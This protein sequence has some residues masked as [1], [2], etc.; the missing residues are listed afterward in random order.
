MRGFN[1]IW[2]HDLR[3]TD[4]ILPTELWSLAGI[5]SSASSI[6]TRYMKSEMMCIYYKSWN[7]TAV[8]DLTGFISYAYNLKQQRETNT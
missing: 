4:V 6:Y 8:K 1:G 7:W 3:D 2:I 5:K